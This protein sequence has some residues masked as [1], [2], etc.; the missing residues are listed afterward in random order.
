MKTGD[1]IRGLRILKGL[2]QENMADLLDL[3]V[4]AYGEIERNKTDLKM[5]RLEQI[6]SILEVPVGE[7]LR[8]GETVS[9][10]FDQCRGA[11]GLNFGNQNN[12]FD[13][14]ESDH[15]VEKLML[16]NR[17]LRSE[18][19]ILKLKLAIAEKEIGPLKK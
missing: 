17:N 19:E 9:N 10:F 8:F 5:S 3:N 13:K 2:S 12:Q 6:A 15:Q 11:I 14:L 1:K 18:I 7:I 16:E 4:L